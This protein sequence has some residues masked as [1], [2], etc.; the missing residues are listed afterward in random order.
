MAKAQ[1]GVGVSEV[2]KPRAPE[3]LDLLGHARKNQLHHTVAAA[4][5]LLA[6]K[7]PQAL[8]ALHRKY[9]DGGELHAVTGFIGGVASALRAG[10]S[11]YG[12][13]DGELRI[14]IR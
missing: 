12:D 7:K 11:V 4:I 8:R 6:H 2:N 14:H 1:S 3:V 13:G 9:V 10:V 5:I